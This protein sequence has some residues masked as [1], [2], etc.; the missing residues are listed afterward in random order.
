MPDPGNRPH[1]KVNGR[2]MLT[3]N[4]AEDGGHLHDTETA[5]DLLR[6]NL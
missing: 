2:L 5:G 4:T 1:L 3:E 6:T